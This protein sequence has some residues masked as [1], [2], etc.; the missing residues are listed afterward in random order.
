MLIHDCAASPAHGTLPGA[1]ATGLW[2]HLRSY[3]WPISNPQLPV[4]SQGCPV[5]KPTGS[6]PA[7][8]EE[9][10]ESQFTACAIGEYGNIVGGSSTWPATAK[11]L[12][13]VVTPI[14]EPIAP[15]TG[16]RYSG[17]L[18]TVAVTR[19]NLAVEAVAPAEFAQPAM[20][21][22]EYSVTVASP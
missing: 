17:K 4:G 7:G 16:N 22:V 20:P 6:V 11:A 10:Q 5:L 3:C 8:S 13:V 9:Y 15:T 2:G 1:A 19:A 14:D 21:S 12:T 18:A